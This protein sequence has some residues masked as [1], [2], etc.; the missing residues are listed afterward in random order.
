[1][2][3][4]SAK[5]NPARPKSMT[6]F[7]VLN[8]II[9]KLKMIGDNDLRKGLE[10]LQDEIHKSFSATFIPKY[11]DKIRNIVQEFK[12]RLYRV[13]PEIESFV[14]ELVAG[15]VK[16][17]TDI[18]NM[19]A[20]Q[21]AKHQS[22]IEFNVY[23]ESELK[24]MGKSFLVA[25]DLTKIKDPI[26]EKLENIT[27]GINNK[28]GFDEQ[29]YRQIQKQLEAIEH[30]VTL[31]QNEA[32]LMEEK[33]KEFLRSSLYDELTGVFNRRGYQEE[34]NK[35]WNIF[36]RYDTVFSLVLFDI[37]EFKAINDTFGH[38]AGDMVLQ[39]VAKGTKTIFRNVDVP[40]RYGGD[41]LIVILPNTDLEQALISAERMRKM[42][43]KNNL[44]YQ[45][46]EIKITISIGVAT[47]NKTDTPGTFF[48]RADKALYVA[49][50]SGKNQ[51]RSEESVAQ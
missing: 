15:L 3:K 9:F 4:I 51:T 2:S 8:E 21:Q 30:Q 33:S 37:D 41:E 40:A 36:K 14:D 20:T 50:N 49:K 5:K 17:E 43:E 7:E 11:I 25:D 16:T 32:K 18:K 26:F 45:E 31:A 48:E 34:F 12:D 29:R 28:K 44:R 35:Q 39:E 47:V 13:H 22:D 1:M 46:K 38:K 10:T 42:I 27:T 19:L 6:A 24:D 23:L